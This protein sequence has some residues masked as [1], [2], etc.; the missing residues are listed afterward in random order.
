MPV[1]FSCPACANVYDTFD[2][3]DAHR[4]SVH[5]RTADGALWI[6]ARSPLERRVAALERQVALLHSEARE[7][8]R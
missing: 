6:D 8:G 7:G 3:L 5:G 1:T 4:K 2:G